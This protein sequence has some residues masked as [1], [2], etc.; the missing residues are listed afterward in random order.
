MILLTLDASYVHTAFAAFLSHMAQIVLAGD[1][2]QT[3]YLKWLAV[4]IA[5]CYRSVDW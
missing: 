5:A 1:S 3:E 2:H 4:N